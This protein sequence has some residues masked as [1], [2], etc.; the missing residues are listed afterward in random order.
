MLTKLAGIAEVAKLRPQEKFTSLAHLINVDMLRMCH[1]EMDGKKATGVDGVTSGGSQPAGVDSP[2]GNA[3]AQPL[4]EAEV[5]RKYMPEIQSLQSV[6]LSRLD[7]L[8]GAAVQ[9]YR[10]EKATGRVNRA[11]LAQKYIQAGNLLEG[12]VDGRFYFYPGL[13]AVRAGLRRPADGSSEGD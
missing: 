5:V 3:T 9:E 1:T 13:Y 6:A 11:A 8:Y 7:T 12:N 10:Q 4:T 2:G